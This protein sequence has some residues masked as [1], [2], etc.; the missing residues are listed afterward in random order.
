[1]PEPEEYSLHGMYGD[2]SASNKL[3]TRVEEV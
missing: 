1:M 2:S 3:V